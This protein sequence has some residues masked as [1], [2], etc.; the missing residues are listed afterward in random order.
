MQLSL[1]ERMKIKLNEF[2]QI[3]INDKIEVDVG[4]SLIVSFIDNSL[5]TLKDES[6]FSVKEFDQTSSKPAFILSI[7]NGKFSFESGSIAKNKEWNN[8]N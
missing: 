2:D 5:L 7:L 6:E 1:K 4:A 3:Y 8:E